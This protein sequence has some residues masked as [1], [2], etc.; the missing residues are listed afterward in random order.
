MTI[1]MRSY[2]NDDYLTVI[3]NKKCKQVKLPKT[4]KVEPLAKIIP[5]VHPVKFQRARDLL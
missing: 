5:G 4:P 1:P 2:L 3:N